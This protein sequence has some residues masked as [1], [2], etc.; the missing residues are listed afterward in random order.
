MENHGKLAGI[1]YDFRRPTLSRL[2]ER[3]WNPADPRIST[4]RVYG[5]GWEI[6]LPTLRE[7]NEAAFYLAALAY[8]CILLQA[9][10]SLLRGIR[11][12]KRLLIR[13]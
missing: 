13:H 4:P 11:R 3:I 7:K 10:R 1:P 9:A 2:K 5:I 6:N 8:L 12:V